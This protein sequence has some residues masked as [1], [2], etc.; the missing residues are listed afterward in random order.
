MNNQHTIVLT[1][2][3]AKILQDALFADSISFVSEPYKSQDGLLVGT[4]ITFQT[5][6]INA[7]IIKLIAKIFYQQLS[8]PINY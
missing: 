4:S 6:D 5:K 8:K 1:S 7:A 2:E 3:F